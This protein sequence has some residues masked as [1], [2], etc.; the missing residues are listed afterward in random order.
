MSELVDMFFIV[1]LNPNNGNIETWMGRQFDTKKEALQFAFT[2]F[3]DFH[4]IE[5]RWVKPII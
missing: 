5:R 1:F 3:K 4:C 2:N